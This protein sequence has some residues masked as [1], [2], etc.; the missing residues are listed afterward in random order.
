MHVCMYLYMY[1][2]CMCINERAR[3]RVCVRVCLW[4]NGLHTYVWKYWH[5]TVVPDG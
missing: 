2:V 4:M 3:A 1:D 5:N